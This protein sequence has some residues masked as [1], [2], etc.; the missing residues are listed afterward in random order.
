MHVQ[1]YKFFGDFLAIFCQL[2]PLISQL[3]RDENKWG[4]HQNLAKTCLKVVTEP[5]FWFRSSFAH[6]MESKIVLF[7]QFRFE[8]HICKSIH[9]HLSTCKLK[10]GFGAL[11]ERRSSQLQER[12][13]TNI[14]QCSD[15]VLVLTDHDFDNFGGEKGCYL[16]NF[17]SESGK[18]MICGSR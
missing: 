12:F 5:D 13:G 16:D 8:L 1:I 14:F 2:S 6:R 15:S 11:N 3:L 18:I 10:H 4:F 9:C 17:N 7:I